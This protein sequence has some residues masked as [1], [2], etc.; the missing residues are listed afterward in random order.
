MLAG[1]GGAGASG[2][3]ST[4]RPA[5][6]ASQYWN[7]HA[8]T[9]RGEAA[10]DV[11]AGKQALIE[12]NVE[13]AQR[14]FAAADHAGPLDHDTN[15]TLWEQRGIAAAFLED[16]QSAASAFDM[17]LA[18]DPGHYL[19]YNLKPDVTLIFERVRE[20]ANQR[21]APEIDIHWPSGLETGKPIPLDVEVLAD[22]K[23][24]LHRASVFLRARGD[25]TWHAADL[26]L[27][28]RPTRLLVPPVEATHP[29]SLE[30]YLR[31]YDDR[32]NEVLSWA[33][34]ARPR[35][36]PLRYDPPTKWYR[37]WKTYAIGG[38]AIAVVTG[39]IVYAV[40][41]SPPGDASGTGVVR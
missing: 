8:C 14:A 34:P 4:L 12:Q 19:S 11:A 37:N 27:G 30:L 6:G 20:Q 21:G 25:T 28:A 5:C 17:M 29:T 3:L 16:K 33:G 9:P 15:V 13:Q 32:G 35:E 41:L 1:C 40:T 24:F 36:I 38:T 2:T 31:A 10:K 23:H 26:G 7:G 39:I 18:L 22:P